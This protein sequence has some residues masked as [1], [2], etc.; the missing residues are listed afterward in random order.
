MEPIELT[1]EEKEVL[2]WVERAGA[3]SPSRLSAQM[4]IT[5]PTMWEMLNHLQELAWVIIRDDPDSADG[6]LVIA[7]GTNMQSKG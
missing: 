6:K 1:P 7:T 3:V 2:A 4:Q 5:P